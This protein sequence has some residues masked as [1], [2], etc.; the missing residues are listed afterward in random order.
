MPEVKRKKTMSFIV[1]KVSGFIDSK[2][3]AATTGSTKAA[4]SAKAVAKDK[5]SKIVSKPLQKPPMVIAPRIQISVNPDDESP[6]TP[7]G[8]KLSPEVG[9]IHIRSAQSDFYT[10]LHENFKFIYRANKHRLNLGGGLSLRKNFLYL[11][12]NF[13][14]L[15]AAPV[16]AAQT[17]VLPVTASSSS[18]TSL[19]SIF[20]VS[21]TSTTGTGPVKKVYKIIDQLAYPFYPLQAE[22]SEL[23][24][25]L[26]TYDNTDLLSDLIKL[27]ASEGVDILPLGPCGEPVTVQSLDD[28]TGSGGTSDA[29]AAAA[30]KLQ[31]DADAAAAALVVAKAECSPLDFA[32]VSAFDEDAFI[33]TGSMF[34]GGVSEDDFVAAPVDPVVEEQVLTV[35]AL[36]DDLKNSVPTDE[37]LNEMGKAVYAND[38]IHEQ[39]IIGLNLVTKYFPVHICITTPN[40]MEGT[41]AARPQQS[42]YLASDAQSF[43]ENQYPDIMELR[44][45]AVKAFPLSHLITSKS[46]NDTTQVWIQDFVNGDLIELSSPEYFSFIFEF[47]T[48]P[49]GTILHQVAIIHKESGA[50]ARSL[51]AA[52]KLFKAELKDSVN[53]FEDAHKYSNPAS[54]TAPVQASHFTGTA[55][56]ASTRMS[57]PMVNGGGD[58]LFG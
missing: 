1:R 31:Q 57:M 55:G 27:A 47:V 21:S 5:A 49:H 14:E 24:I 38:K 35:R 23:A 58:S 16:T 37:E 30:L 12:W 18:T 26:R 53:K 3:Q 52:D 40:T 20:N 41:A 9:I 32:P 17:Q 28:G 46:G 2:S 39:I 56:T 4:G 42:V 13:F 34:L 11:R 10:F 15:V 33:K 7:S 29:D 25:T 8:P 43:Y 6:Y 22:D 36:E 44:R 50:V 54:L 19:S 51:N 45:I 48:K